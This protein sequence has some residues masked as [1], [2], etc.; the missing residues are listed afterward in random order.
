MTISAVTI[1]SINRLIDK[2]AIKVARNE[3]KNASFAQCSTHR[4]GKNM[5]T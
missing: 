2:A 4:E 5:V 3:V 1:R